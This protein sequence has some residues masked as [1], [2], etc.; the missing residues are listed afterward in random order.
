M[1]LQLKTAIISD[2][3]GNNPA[4]EAVLADAAVHG[5][6]RYVFAGDYVFDAPF[7]NESVQTMMAL[8]NTYAI[9]GNK[10]GYL[11][12]LQNDKEINWACKQMGS[13]FQSFDELTP[14]NIAYLERL[15]RTLH[16]PMDR[17][18]IY[19]THSIEGLN[20]RARWNTSTSLFHDRMRKQSFSYQDY[21]R[22]FA[23][24]LAD[25]DWLQMMAPIDA[26]VIVFGHNH[27]Q[28]HG[29]CGSKLIINPGSCGVP[30][31]GDNRAAY[32]ILEESKDGLAVTER[33]VPYDVEDL[34]RKMMA[35]PTYARGRE[36][37]EICIL[38]WRT[39]IDHIHDVFAIA[40]QIAGA[41]GENG[42][43]FADET[44]GEAYESFCQNYKPMDKKGYQ[45]G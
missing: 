19:V 35:S 24:M 10:E 32:T 17:G 21:A 25:D 40:R 36:W 23:D 43:F 42:M 29:Y 12:W 7:P 13:M 1:G 6:D 5:V 2:I 11:D 28:G 26:N 18:N 39:G 33:R 22:A 44:W 8:P 34:I 20:Y 27:L 41:K 45:H 15:P 37:C 3:H 4:L 31:D 16:V 9:A 30:M 14:E 38:N